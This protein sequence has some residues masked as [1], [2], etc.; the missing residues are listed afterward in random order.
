MKKKIYLILILFLSGWIFS[1][2]QYIVFKNEKDK[3]T[4]EITKK[5]TELIAYKNLLEDIQKSQ[6]DIDEMVKVL[7]NLKQKLQTIEDKIKKGDT[8]GS[9]SSKNSQ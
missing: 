5:E 9:E 2:I 1:G 3:L 7:N 8:N 4:Q 6:K